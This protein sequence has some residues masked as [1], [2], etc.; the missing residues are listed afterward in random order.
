MPSSVCS[1]MH[2]DAHPPTPQARAAYQIVIRRSIS[3]GV[4]FGIAMAVLRGTT[5][6]N[7]AVPWP[8]LNQ[9]GLPWVLTQP[10]FGL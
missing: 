10:L 9:Q 7:L 4:S 3:S 6:I 5:N 1:H 2:A 8:S